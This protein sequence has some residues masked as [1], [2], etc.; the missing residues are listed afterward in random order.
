[1]K[2]DHF[3]A[4]CAACNS[5]F[6]S[7]GTEVINWPLCSLC[8]RLRRN[9]TRWQ[10]GVENN[11]TLDQAISLRSILARHERKI[12]P[13]NNKICFL[14]SKLKNDTLQLT[15]EE[16]AQILANN[17][18]HGKYYFSSLVFMVLEKFC[19]QKDHQAALMNVPRLASDRL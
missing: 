7:K 16:F 1:M 15:W 14:L 18:L 17:L 13:E 5:V 11:L 12:Q 10:V 4:T 6:C 19:R 8:N 2:L 3:C 9:L